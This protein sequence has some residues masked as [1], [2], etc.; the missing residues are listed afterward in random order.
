M[1]GSPLFCILNGIADKGPGNK[2]QDSTN[3]S[4]ST[5]VARKTPDGST[6]TRAKNGACY[7]SSFPMGQG[8]GTSRGQSQYGYQHPRKKFFVVATLK[9]H[10][11]FF[12]ASLDSSSASFILL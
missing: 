1:Q 5:S 9:L 6:S 2:S 12:L 10:H 4:T 7:S 3:G 8:R 11:I